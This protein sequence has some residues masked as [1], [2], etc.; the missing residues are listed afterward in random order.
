MGNKVYDEPIEVKGDLREYLK[1]VMSNHARIYN[2]ALSHLK[3]N[4]SISFQQLKEDIR[5]LILENNIDDYI[6]SI[7]YTEIHYLYKRFQQKGATRK[8]P[9]GILYLS[10]RTFDFSKSLFG[11]DYKDLELKFRKQNG[12][13]ELPKPL[14][15]P[16]RGHM[17]Y[18][19]ISYSPTGDNFRASVFT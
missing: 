11:F 5:K 7:L 19:N 6:E 18:L 16:P 15:P 17:S 9:F 12:C 1:T 4:S 2:L 10:V 13:I 14:P 3:K 8:N